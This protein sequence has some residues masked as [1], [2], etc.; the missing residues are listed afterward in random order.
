MLADK[1]NNPF[2]T[3]ENYFDNFL[4]TLQLKTNLSNSKS[5]EVFKWSATFSI[6]AFVVFFLVEPVFN[7]NKI[8]NELTAE[9]IYQLFYQEDLDLTYA[10]LYELVP[11]D[12]LYI[13]HNFDDLIEEDLEYFEVL[14]EL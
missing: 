11:V 10:M 9:E 6:L 7:N 13:E 14:H 1:K 3:P 8:Q 5:Y 12:S 4:P 2:K